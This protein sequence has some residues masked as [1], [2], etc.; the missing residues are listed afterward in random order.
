M[1]RAHAI[2]VV[3]ISTLWTFA[4]YA[5]QIDAATP[6]DIERMLQVTGTRDRLQAMLG[7]MAQQTAK[8][9]AENFKQKNPD[10]SQADVQ[11]AAQAAG[12]RA[13]AMLRAMP[14]DE[15]VQAMVPIYQKH[16]SHSDVK[17][18][19]EFYSS[20]TGQKLLKESNAMVLESMQAAST[21][22]QKHMPEIEAQA[23]KA[24]QQ[25]AKPA[26]SANPK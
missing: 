4:A 11:K 23:D 2:F 19:I 15:M 22:V 7:T 9:A 3:L 18:I 24:A 20:P 1:N 17:A 14:V 6:E 5:Q 8:H 16:L 25:T 13:Q 21:V 10:A 26:D 12:E